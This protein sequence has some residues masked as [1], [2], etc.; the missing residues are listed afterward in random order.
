MIMAT[1][2]HRYNNSRVDDICRCS[3]MEVCWLIFTMP[4]DGND[5]DDDSSNPGDPPLHP[6]H[7]QVS[8][9]ICMDF[10][11]GAFFFTGNCTGVWVE[12]L[13]TNANVVS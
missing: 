13:I 1:L 2:S 11:C 10:I 5:D 8:I 3:C 7:H 4:D 6:H 12:I 9:I